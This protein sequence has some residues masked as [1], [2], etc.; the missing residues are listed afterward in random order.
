MSAGISALAIVGVVGWQ[1]NKVIQGKNAD[2]QATA[3]AAVSMPGGQG[4][5]AIGDM[6]GAAT[7]S[8]P[9]DIAQIGT[10]AIGELM[11]RYTIATKN[12]P[13]TPEL[14]A[15]IV[16]QVA[17]NVDARVAYSVY[18]AKML[19]TDPD[20]SYVRMGVYRTDLQAALKPLMDNKRYELDIYND[21]LQT[22]D[23]S[24]LAQLKTATNNYRS[25]AAQ[26]AKI[27]VPASASVYHVGILNAMQ[28]FAATLDAMA[29]NIND[30]VTS[31][32]L[33][34]AYNKAEDDMRGSFEALNARFA[35]K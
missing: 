5:N 4:T 19:P 34:K 6:S 16:A 10:N 22:R 2:L 35:Q 23:A 33:L 15:Q 32:A 17:P 7:S 8:S 13:Y 18:D 27:V 1:V 30:P 14:G 25:A 11:T 26:T 9:E 24:R 3:A 31:L 28:E 20:T 12:T 29:D 21:Y